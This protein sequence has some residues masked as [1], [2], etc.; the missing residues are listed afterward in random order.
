MSNVYTYRL[1][2]ERKKKGLTQKDMANKLGYKSITTYSNIERGYVDPGIDNI[3][4]I[5][6]ILGKSVEYF[7]N[8][9]V[10]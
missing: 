2:K 8:L 7:F 3:N 10:Q 5:S 4:K 1:I 9:N 6:K